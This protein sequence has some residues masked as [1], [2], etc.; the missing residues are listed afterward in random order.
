MSTTCPNCGSRL[1]EGESDCPACLLLGALDEPDEV[2]ADPPNESVSGHRIQGYEFIK[3]IGTGGTSN[4]FLARQTS[5]IEREVALKLI[6]PG[7]N[8]DRVVARFESEREVLAKLRHPN[9][10]SIHDAGRTDTGAPYFAME[11]VEGL[12]VTEFATR[13]ELSL[14]ARLRLNLNNWPKLMVS[15]SHKAYT[16]VESEEDMAISTRLALVE[17]P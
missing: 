5:P 6:R 8:S 3:Q 14:E 12:P 11:Y 7:M 10:A 17:K 4:V 9:I 2:P 15:P 13:H 16:I 1:A